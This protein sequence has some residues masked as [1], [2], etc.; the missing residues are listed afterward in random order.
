VGF[1]N[2]DARQRAEQFLATEDP[3]QRALRLRSRELLDAADAL[4]SES[5]APN[6]AQLA[7]HRDAVAR[8]LEAFR[9]VSFWTGRGRL[10]AALAAPES[11][12][13]ATMLRDAHRVLVEEL[14]APLHAW[15]KEQRQAWT[16][17]G[18]V[19]FA[20]TGLIT[21]LVFLVQWLRQPEDLAR[22]KPFTL[23]S[24][25]ADCHPDRYECGGYPT[26]ILF[27]TTDQDQPW[28]QLDLGA[29]TSFSWLTIKNRSDM[30]MM[31]AIPLV[32]EVSDD[33]ATFKEVARRTE[34][35]TVW[36]PRF[37]PQLARYVRLRV[38]RFSTL[39]LDAVQVHR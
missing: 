37:A 6:A 10:E 25:W 36:E 19:A 24:K 39:H 11:I 7:L 33:G 23:S 9:P 34:R 8:I 5:D 2:S 12:A 15:R 31:R 30:A 21:G 20:L 27:H 32:V 1:F 14:E 26:P 35:F 17:A 3:A 29:P 38:D 18:F 13:A 28:F 22:G 16:R 4:V